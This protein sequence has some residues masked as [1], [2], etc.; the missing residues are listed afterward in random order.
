MKSFI[1]GLIMNKSFASIAFFHRNAQHDLI[2]YEKLQENIFAELNANDDNESEEKHAL[3]RLKNRC[4]LL[5][6]KIKT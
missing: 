1:F 2:H 6:L 5:G 4:A 3:H